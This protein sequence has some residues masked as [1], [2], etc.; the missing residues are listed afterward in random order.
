M[1]ERMNPSGKCYSCRQDQHASGTAGPRGSNAVIISLPVCVCV[2][3]SVSRSLL[4]STTLVSFS[5]N[6]PV[7]APAAL[8]SRYPHKEQSWWKRGFSS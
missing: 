3:L 6:L 1:P 8:G 5:S 4:H 7:G 2:C